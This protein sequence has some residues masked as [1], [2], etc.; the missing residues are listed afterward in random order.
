[1]THEP[2]I[3]QLAPA[4]SAQWLG[5]R[6]AR[7]VDPPGTTIKLAA[8]WLFH[9]LQQGH[10]CLDFDLPVVA[11]LRGSKASDER[12][13]SSATV[14][15]AWLADLANHP[16]VQQESA[17]SRTAS[18]KLLVLEGRKL[19]L[20]ACRHDEIAVANKLRAMAM[21]N[22]AWH[23][24]QVEAQCAAA[25]SPAEQAVA[26]A[27]RKQLV[28]VT[29][30][31]GT[32]KTTI[33]ARMADAILRFEAVDIALIAP[34][35]KAAKRLENSMRAAAAGTGLGVPTSALL[36]ASAATTIHAAVRAR[37]EH[38][39][40]CK[41][42][43]I[44]DECSMIDLALMRELLEKLHKAATLILLGDAHQLA[45]VEA[46]SVLA[47]ILPRE[48]DLA[49][50]LAHCTVRLVDNYRFPA[51]GVVAQLAAAVNDGEWD[52]VRDVL[53]SQ[54]PQCVRWQ[55]ARDSREVVEA[56]HT[57][58]GTA[59]ESRVLCGH[60][61]GPDG[62]LA[63]NRMLAT[64]AGGATNP[65]PL[66]GDDFDGRPIIVTVND[67]VTGLRNGDIGVVQRT[68]AGELVAKIEGGDVSFAL[69]QLPRHEAAYA[70]TIHKSQGSEYQRVIVVLP[71]Q[72][73]PVV[74]RE[75]LYTAITRTQGDLLIIATEE[76]LRGAV[77]QCVQ[78]ASGM[79]ERMIGAT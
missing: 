24:A 54:T 23:D 74:T 60:R 45:S 4:A 49:H 15:A 21:S 3:D 7:V 75:L 55:M 1:M 72:P 42:L 66:E 40:A 43:V 73:S 33:A 77:A 68:A 44:V 48:G 9:Q 25:K 69:A 19:F 6:L 18:D 52:R 31:P 46:G 56:C 76:S 59:P 70:L 22:S 35:G 29:G 30:G 5:E 78:R 14:P 63:I 32:G 28:I 13:T 16:Q 67:E 62:A 17:G 47:D 27:R 58:F 26:V 2:S 8:V 64:R 57:A 79:R 20:A 11:A 10:T 65:D 38:A 34:T 39:L 12:A 53:S 41:R 37:G 50:P 71:A 36:G 61:R 51:T